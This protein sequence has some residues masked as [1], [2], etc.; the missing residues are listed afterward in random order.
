MR[1][2]V[3]MSHCFSGKVA[4]TSPMRRPLLSQTLMKV[5]VSNR[6]LGQRCSRPKFAIKVSA[7]RLMC[8][9][10]G[11]YPGPLTLLQ[12]S[13]TL[14]LRM[15]EGEGSQGKYIT[16]QTAPSPSQV[17]SNLLPEEMQPP[18]QPPLKPFSRDCIPAYQLPRRAPPRK[19][20]IGFPTLVRTVLT[21]LG[22][23]KR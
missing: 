2:S 8:H 17:C 9:L 14:L 4:R 5:T 20:E 16:W 13:R 10:G 23:V 6:D 1:D 12:L 15:R 18:G 19:L 11:C 3:S 22:W 21:P 7:C